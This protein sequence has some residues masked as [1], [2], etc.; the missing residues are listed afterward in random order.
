[1]SNID[2]SASAKL[3]ELS[4]GLPSGRKKDVKQAEELNAKN[5]SDH[6]H[7]VTKS[8]L[9]GSVVLENAIK[10]GAQIRAEHTRMTLPYNNSGL[11]LVTNA[12][13]VDYLAYMNDA[14]QEQSEY[15]DKFLSEYPDIIAN[16]PTV[17]GAA[18]KAEDYPSY[19][20]MA[21]KFRWSL[22]FYPVPTS[23][24]FPTDIANE[25]IAKFQA[26]D[27]ARIQRAMGDVYGRMSKLITRL[28]DQLQPDK[29]VY[30]SLIEG[31]RELC[32]NIK[33]MNLTGDPQLEGIRQELQKAM[34]GVDAVD[35]RSDEAYRK[36]VKTK[37]DDILNKFNF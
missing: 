4:I 5:N 16:A 23:G 34:L 8:T 18:Y 28:S 19:G 10:H 6:V 24:H 32:D 9:K 31:A 15:R 22:E 27:D 25:M 21:D 7:N 36:D 12:M 2:I 14:E 30:N 26:D 17:M 29:K 35:I 3:V 1:M 11:R 20:V 33:S 13:L 37:V